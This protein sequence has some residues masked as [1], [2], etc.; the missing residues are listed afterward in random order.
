MSAPNE[1]VTILNANE[2][3]PVRIV[4]RNRRRKFLM[5][6]A[7]KDNSVDIFIQPS[8]Q[9]DADNG[10]RLRAGESMSF[11]DLHHL[12]ANDFDLYGIHAGADE[13]D[14]TVRIMEL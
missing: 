14:P 11:P 13:A 6:Q 5:V 10:I 3:G 2:G 9:L 1:P 4:A 7:D 12:G 8:K